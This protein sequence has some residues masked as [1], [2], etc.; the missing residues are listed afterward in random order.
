MPML[1]DEEKDRINDW[2]KRE[3]PES[4]RCPCCGTKA[5]NLVSFM[6]GAPVL[7]RRRDP[8]QV[9]NG[10]QELVAFTCAKCSFVRYHSASDMGV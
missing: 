5:W 3:L 10:F 6:L 7:D 2:L 1:T 4:V 9:P 8:V